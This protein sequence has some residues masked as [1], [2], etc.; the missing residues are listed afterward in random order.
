[1]HEGLEDTLSLA[2]GGILF[3]FLLYLWMK[4]LSVVFYFHFNN[5]IIYTIGDIVIDLFY[6]KQIYKQAVN[7]GTISKTKHRIYT[8]WKK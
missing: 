7:L 3:Y 5:D 6:I 2:V 8:F 1:M 4:L